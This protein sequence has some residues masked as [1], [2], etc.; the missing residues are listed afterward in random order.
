MHVIDK[1]NKVD[2]KQT[3]DVR[4]TLEE[5]LIINSVFG[6][7]SSKAKEDFI[8]RE[9]NHKLDVKVSSG[10]YRNTKEILKNEG[11]ESSNWI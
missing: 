1:E 3:V 7:T 4:M 9:I 8:S 11:I 5:L 2:L 10:I 6:S